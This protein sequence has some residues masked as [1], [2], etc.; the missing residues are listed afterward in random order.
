MKLWKS[1]FNGPWPIGKFLHLYLA[2]L[3][4]HAWCRVT[5]SSTESVAPTD[6]KIWSQTN[7]KPQS[8]QCTLFSIVSHSSLTKSLE[9][10]S[11]EADIYIYREH[12]RSRVQRRVRRS[13]HLLL[14]KQVGD[15]KFRSRLFSPFLL[16]LSPTA[17]EATTFDTWW[18]PL[19]SFQQPHEES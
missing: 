15:H 18:P 19:F 4:L 14:W 2:L 17:I 5:K 6:H 8:T 9:Y 12:E 7:F 3:L 10:W 16:V 13:W 11:C 1:S